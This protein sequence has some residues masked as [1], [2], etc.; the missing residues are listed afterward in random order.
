M[1]KLLCP[2]PICELINGIQRLLDVHYNSDKLRVFIEENQENSFYAPIIL[3]GVFNWAYSMEKEIEKRGGES[4][5]L[6]KIANKCFDQGFKFVFGKVFYDEFDFPLWPHNFIYRRAI[7][8]LV[9]IEWIHAEALRVWH[10]G[11]CQSR[12]GKEDGKK[13]WMIE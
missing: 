9:M 1:V 12:F 2:D 13:G 10:N 8:A 4:F 7:S 6:S 3:S 11:R 5:D